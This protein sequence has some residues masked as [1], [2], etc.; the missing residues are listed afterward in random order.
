M[1]FATCQWFTGLF[2]AILPIVLNI[3]VV[4]RL[5]R[6]H[7]ADNRSSWRHRVAYVGAASN[8]SVYC[9]PVALLSGEHYADSLKKTMPIR[10]RVK[11]GD[12]SISIP[13]A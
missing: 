13:A 6:W 7:A 9:L 1:I 8:I 11:P 5:R 12:P 4:H 2:A 10:L 3:D